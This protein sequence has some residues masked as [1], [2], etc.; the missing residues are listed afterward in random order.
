MIICADAMRL[1][2]ANNSVHCVA[3]SPPYFGL[4]DYGVTGQ[5]GLEKTPEEYVAKMVQVFREVRRVLR[6]DGTCWVNMGDSYNGI[7]W[8]GKQDGG[9]IGPTAAVAIEGTKG[10]RISSLKP[11]DLVGAPWRVAFALQADGWWLRQDIIWHKPNPMPE[12]VTDRCTKAHEYLFLLTKRARYWYDAEGIREPL[13]ESALP[14]I[15]AGRLGATYDGKGRGA[16]AEQGK[17]NGAMRTWTMNTAGANRRSVWTIP[18]QAFSEAHFA[19][20]PEA[21]V[22][23]CVNAGCPAQCCPVCGKGWRRV[24]EKTRTF[25]SGSGKS[26]NMPQGKNGAWMQ[27]GGETLDIRRGPCV[28]TTTLGWKPSC[29]CGRTD[30]VPGIVFDPFTGSGTTGI[31]ALKSGRRFVGTE[32][33]R[34][35][36]DMANRRI[37]AS[38]GLFAG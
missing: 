3:T 2:L 26:G 5:L 15:A 30:S 13:S 16:Y 6:D 10:R 37:S 21:L 35:Y 33:K 14:G 22:W 19:T 20:Y 31:V 7:G 25:E 8:P 18:T 32:L 1:P 38:A 17:A 23:P 34:E 36:I 12:S 29:N 27:G 24:V 11:K 4:R 28:S 9:P